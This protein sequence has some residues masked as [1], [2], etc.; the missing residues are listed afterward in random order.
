MNR[1]SCFDSSENNTRENVGYSNEFQA[2]L[3]GLDDEDS[4]EEYNCSNGKKKR[5]RIDQVQALERIFEVDNKLDPERKI[6]LAQELGLQPRQVA[7]WFQNRRARWKTKQLERDYHLLKANY[8]ALQLNYSKVEQEKEGLVAELR[9]LREKLGEDNTETNHSIEKVATL[10]SSPKMA[11]EKCNDSSEFGPTHANHEVYTNLHLSSETK[12]ILDLKDGL[13]DSDS[14]GVLNEDS[15]SLNV[16]P[17]VSKLSSCNPTFN[18]L[19]QY[20]F[21]LSAP[22]YHPHLLDSRV[23]DYQQQFMKMQDQNHS[24]YADDS[25]NIFSV[26]QAPPLYWYFSDPRNQ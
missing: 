13:S 8:E 17:L 6:K 15:N 23:K 1:F 2:M 11:S 5:L 14:S 16:Q 10:Q 7:I 4:I 26:D 19:D 24:S 20:A 3:D 21:S 12:R 18:G 25:C 22:V 9:G